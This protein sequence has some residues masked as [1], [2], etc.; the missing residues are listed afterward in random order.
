[1]RERV[2]YLHDSLL[3]EKVYV[4][5]VKAYVLWAARSGDDSSHPREMAQ[6]EVEGFLTN[7]TNI[8]AQC[9]TSA[10]PAR[11]MRWRCR[12]E[13]LR[14]R[15]FSARPAPCRARSPLS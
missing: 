9:G 2:R 12:S 14:P 1:V 4:Y 6:A 7:L 5:L 10:R 8:R 3:T 13:P 11:R 15:D